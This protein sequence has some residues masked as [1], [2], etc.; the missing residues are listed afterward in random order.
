M[1]KSR[2]ALEVGWC[3][4]SPS[5][6]SRE[7]PS[8]TSAVA[9]KASCSGWKMPLTTDGSAA[10]GPLSH[11][12]RRT[13]SPTSTDVTSGERST[14]LSTRR[15]RRA[16]LARRGAAAAAAAAAAHAWAGSREA[17]ALLML[18]V[19][20]VTAAAA[21]SASASAASA[22][23]HSMRAKARGLRMPSWK[24]ATR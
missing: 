13:A 11:S 6:G 17:V 4:S 23:P 22:A 18:L 12:T 16:R 24:G 20:L 7:R 3:T 19:L 14:F 1:P 9:V 10:S 15:T 21:A 2:Q 8:V 5:F